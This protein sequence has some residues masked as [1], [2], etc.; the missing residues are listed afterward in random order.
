LF[1]SCINDHI[2]LFFIQL[3]AL[4][5]LLQ[6]CIITFFTTQQ[7]LKK[8]YKNCFGAGLPNNFSMAA[9][10][11]SFTVDQLANTPSRKCGIDSE[12]EISY[13]QQAASLIQDMGQKLQVYPFV[14]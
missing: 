8:V 7:N 1:I 9:N 6:K 10:R 14:T 3:K 5:L 4:I 11:W 13:R 12:K 2:Y